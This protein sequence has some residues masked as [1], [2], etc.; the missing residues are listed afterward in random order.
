[1]ASE[2]SELTDIRSL[3]SAVLEATAAG[4]IELRDRI[5][6]TDSK[7]VLYAIVGNTHPTI[8]TVKGPGGPPDVGWFAIHA[9]GAIGSAQSGVYAVYLIA[10]DGSAAF[11][12]LNQ[13]TETVK[14][15]TGVLRKR[16]LDIQ[17][18]AGISDAGAVIDLRSENQRPKNY[19]AASAFAI[20][21]AR[22][23]LPPETELVSDL[24]FIIG[25]V[26]QVQGAGL[27]FPS[28]EEP[29]HLVFKWSPATQPETLALHQDVAE[30][31]G[32]VW[33]G[34]FGTGRINEAKL[35]RLQGQL[36][37]GVPTH[38]YLRGPDGSFIRTRLHEFTV[39][40]ADID[41]GRM[42]GH[43]GIDE[44]SAFARISDFESLGGEWPL[45]HL[46]LQSQ[47]VPSVLPGALQ[48]QQTPLYVYERWTR[49]DAP[50]PLTERAG[51]SRPTPPGRALDNLAKQTLWPRVALEELL[52]SLAWPEGPGQAILAGPPGTGKTWVAEHVAAFLT[53][54]DDSARRT[55]QLHPSYGY[56]EFVE[57]IRPVV[58][59]GSLVFSR[60]DGVVLDL[61]KQSPAATRRVLVV[62]ELNR[63]NVPRAFG[64]LLYL[65]EYRGSTIKLQ[66][67]DDFSLPENFSM[68][69]TMNTADR[70][71]RS[72]DAAL[73]RRFD[74][75][76]CPP[77]DEILRRFFETPGYAAR[78]PGVVDGFLKLNERLSDELD[79]HHTI[80]HTFYM[81]RGL[82]S[83]ELAR[84]WRRQ[85]HPLIEDY[86][87]DRPDLA[88]AY[89]FNAFWPDA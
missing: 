13:G 80:G 21:Y 89:R 75:F 86:F 55:V 46:L 74:I 76:E 57:G 14:G 50:T 11:L 26:D 42:A 72:I 34:K 61:I 60:T 24:E 33:W 16:A 44:C 19:T 69:A 71:T 45:S 64:E 18:A 70:S 85:I 5:I 38:V 51:A 22:K 30:R 37:S 54:G 53:E 52:E 59:G 87:F 77:S 4:D 35:R 79:R 43:Y 23:A 82:T 25:L 78:A 31:E 48:N 6:K 40:P 9:K 12:S 58:D 81:R 41:Q 1:M 32:S 28:D 88:A 83:S 56:E 7:R 47:P 63:A 73:R 65:L 3:L 49:E 15:G 66:Y 68:I 36:D 29:L 8:S 10:A 17:S 2:N 62:D 27:Q 39:D 67:S 20:A 84:T